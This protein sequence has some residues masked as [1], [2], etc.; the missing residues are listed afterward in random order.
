MEASKEGKVLRDFRYGCIGYS[1]Y[2]DQ[3][4]RTSDAQ[5]SEPELPVCIGL[6]VGFMTVLLLHVLVTLILLSILGLYALCRVLIQEEI[7]L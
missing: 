6:E 1:L 7:M 2:A 4:N 3:K 5:Q